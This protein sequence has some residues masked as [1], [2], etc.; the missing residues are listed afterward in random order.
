MRTFTLAENIAALV[1]VGFVFLAM[2]KKSF[3]HCDTLDG[4]VIADAR[5]GLQS[6]NIDPVLKWVR[7]KDEKEI[8]AAFAHALEVRKGGKAALELADKYF[9]ETLVRVHRAGEGAAYTG[10]KPADDVDP[11]IVLAD[12]ALAD[13]SVDKMARQLTAAVEGA[14]REKF[15]LALAARERA[16]ESVVAGRKYVAH[17]VDFTHFAESLHGLLRHSSDGHDSEGANH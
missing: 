6:G 17:Y 9:F 15:Q 8:R 16:D 1:L 10:L 4:P 3:G 7:Y 13:G 12:E 2:P 5:V 14:I 11:V